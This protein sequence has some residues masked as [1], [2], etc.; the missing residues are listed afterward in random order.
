MTNKV[1]FLDEENSKQRER[2]QARFPLAKETSSVK[3]NPKN[4]ILEKQKM[5]VMSYV[6]LLKTKDKMNHSLQSY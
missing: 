5:Y 1:W 3:K 4:V 6:T 2:E